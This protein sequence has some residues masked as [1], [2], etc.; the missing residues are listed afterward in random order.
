MTSRA[1]TP[2]VTTALVGGLI[3]AAL[4]VALV[5][6]VGVSWVMGERS[7]LTGK[8]IGI[9]TIG[10]AP[11]IVSC[12]PGG[13]GDAE[14]VAGNSSR[15]PVVWSATAVAGSASTLPISESVHG[16]DVRSSTVVGPDGTFAL[17]RLTNDRGVN[18]LG[19]I[20]SFDPAEIPEGSVRTGDGQV[21]T[22]TDFK[23]RNEGCGL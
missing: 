18:A 8:S 7:G 11:T 20:I 4:L 22:I 6:G 3:L 9:A 14:I 1:R 17:I 2:I 13:I 19:S 15:S 21:I 23:A 10:G 12:R 16:Y 5:V